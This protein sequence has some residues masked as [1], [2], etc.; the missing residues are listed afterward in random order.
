[1]TDAEQVAKW[2]GLLAGARKWGRPVPWQELQ[3]A[4]DMV[5][6]IQAAWDREPDEPYHGCAGC[7]SMEVLVA[8][9]CGECP[10]PDG[11]LRW[12]R[13]MPPPESPVV[14]PAAHNPA[15]IDHSATWPEAA[16]ESP[17][18]P[19]SPDPA[20]AP[21][22]TY[23]EFAKSHKG[24]DGREI[25]RLWQA[26]KAGG[27][28]QSATEPP[29]TAPAGGAARVPTKDGRDASGQGGLDMPAL[30]P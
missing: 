25:G 10:V 7:G 24:M 17:T 13:P 14:H 30:A 26:R 5:E 19:P 27:Q 2:R 23:R 18:V 8:G 15:M 21:I 22:L 9:W 20:P 4:V 1:M 6:R 28:G 12:L 3:A 29:S 11:A 16:P